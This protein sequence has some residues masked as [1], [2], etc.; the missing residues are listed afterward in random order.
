M[1]PK[2]R[3]VIR[4]NELRRRRLTAMMTQEQLAVASGVSVGRIRQLEGPEQGIS[5]QT[6]R[7]LADTLGCD[8]A[9]ISQVVEDKAS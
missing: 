2:P 1:N 8:P 6:L 3:L 5:I 4:K 9:E 7:K